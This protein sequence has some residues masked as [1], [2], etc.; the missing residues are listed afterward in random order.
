MAHKAAAGVGM[1]KVHVVLHPRRGGSMSRGSLEC[2]TPD[3]PERQPFSLVPC[4]EEE[5]QHKE[6][7]PV[8]HTHRTQRANLQ[9]VKPV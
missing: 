8:Y 1:I 9:L 7:P 4:L 6:A 3:Y 5:A 2:P